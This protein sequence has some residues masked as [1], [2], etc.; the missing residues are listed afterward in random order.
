MSLVSQGPNG[1]AQNILNTAGTVVA[2]G[3]ITVNLQQAPVKGD[4]L[5]LFYVEGAQTADA[6]ISSISQPGVTWG[7]LLS[8]GS[9]LRD[10]MWVGLAGAGASTVITVTVANGNTVDIQTI[11]VLEFS[12]VTSVTP[13]KTATSPASTTP[14]NSTGI[15]A[16]TTQN[17][18]LWIGLIS[19][20]YS[21][22]AGH[23]PQSNPTNGFILLD[24]AENLGL[25]SLDTSLGVLYKAV[26]STGP[27][28]SS[29]TFGNTGTHGQ[30]L[31]ATFFAVFP[32]KV[33]VQMYSDGLTCV[34]C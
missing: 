2:S 16:V 6:T 10:E 13:D 23:T 19:G 33:Q 30:G 12:G 11:D 3:N 20:A 34:V 21:S 27:A 32:A 7:N 15:T 14:P 26:T 5:F 29:D 4:V 22:G 17:N 25:N 8:D 24:G 18:E 28:S 31:I 9:Y 1:Y